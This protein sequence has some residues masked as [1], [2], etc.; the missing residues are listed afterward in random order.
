MTSI[1][2]KEEKI[3]FQG[4]DIS[5]NQD[6]EIV[7]QGIND[8]KPLF[9]DQ[10]FIHYVGSEV[11]GKIFVNSRD[12]DEKFNFS[13]G[14]G[15]VIPAWDLGVATMKRGEIARFFSIPKYAYGSKGEKK[16]QS[17]TSVI[18][19]IEL[20]D[21]VD[22]S[23]ENDGSIIRR[24]IRRGEGRKS[25]N[26]DGTVE[27]NLKGIYKDNVF[28]ERTVQFIVGLG[29]LQ[30]IPLGVERAVCKMLLNEH[31]QLVLKAK[32]L[33]GLEKFS[34]PMNESI[35]YEVTLV[36][37]ERLEEE[38]L[39]NDKEKFEQAELLKAR[40]DD[41]NLKGI[42][43][44]NVFDERT[45]QFIVGLGFLQHIPLGVERAVCKM[46][47]NE[48]C[49]LVLKA[50]ALQGLEKFSI[51]MNESIQYEVTLVRF[52]R[53]EEERSLNDKEKFEQAELLK[54][55]ADDLVKNSYYELAAK[56]YQIVTNLLSSATF[57]ET[58]DT[59][60]L[61]QLKIA[62][63][64]NLALCY[65][66]LGDYR[67]CKIFCDNALAL[68]A[69]N[70]KCLFRRGQVY[71]AFSN[72]EQAIKDFQTAL[73]INPSNVAAQQQIEHCRQQKIKQKESYKAFFNDTS[74]PG[75]FDVDE[76]V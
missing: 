18:F 19:E 36:K 39:L 59:I 11:D 52:E 13:L 30:H 62:T 63:Q 68:D 28:D 40:V 4:E 5:P 60:K 33:Q 73:K 25:P 41:V 76:K 65:L 57:R 54:A 46:L 12:R 49:Q 7:R 56:R 51:P 53:L 14:K 66:K 16:Y 50:K 32:A 48:H 71:I 8:D 27:I 42:Y 58:N 69:R 29:F 75:L 15:E 21:F 34:I 67:Q 24:I 45:V 23:D 64:S 74:K 1:Q 26:E 10:A 9:D 72:F 38:R 70:E 37:F 47:L 3:P 20:L 55:R 22:L 61:R 6:K 43:K 2:L 35:Q 31:C 44:D 17:A